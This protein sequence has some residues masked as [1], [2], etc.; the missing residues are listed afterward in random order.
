M[1]QLIDYKTG[2]ADTKFNAVTDLF[3]QK[4]GDKLRSVFQ[5][6]IYIWAYINC[7]EENEK[8]LYNQLYALKSIHRTGYPEEIIYARKKIKEIHINEWLNE[9]EVK[10]IDIYLKKTGVLLK[11][12]ENDD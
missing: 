10:M 6:L 12:E 4:T 2:K 11:L 7:D 3:D 9:F 5:A 8:L 1:L